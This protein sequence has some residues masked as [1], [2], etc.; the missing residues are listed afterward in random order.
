MVK[1]VI[2]NVSDTKKHA[3]NLRNKYE[4][5][6][7]STDFLYEIENL[8]EHT[9]ILN[10]AQITYTHLKFKVVFIKKM[11]KMLIPW[12]IILQYFYCL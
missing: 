2:Y 5:D 4:K 8:K 9:F 10:G 7:N 1:Y 12:E 6:L 11:C 3:V